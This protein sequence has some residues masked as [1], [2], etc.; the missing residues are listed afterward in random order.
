MFVCTLFG[1]DR[2]VYYRRI[3]KNQFQTASGFGSYQPGFGNQADN[4]SNR[5]KKTVLSF[6][7]SIASTQNRQG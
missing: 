6:K 4:A 5:S 1:I 3:K 2:Q 7:S